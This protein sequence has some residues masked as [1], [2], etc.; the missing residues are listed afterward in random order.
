MPFSNDNAEAM[1]FRA[2]LRITR[3][4]SRVRDFHTLVTLLA[5]ETSNALDVERSTVFLYSPKTDELWSY[6]AEGETEEI[7][8]N[9]S[10][11]VAGSVF[12]TGKTLILD[13]VTHDERFNRTIDDNTGFIT[14]NMI[15]TPVVNPSGVC[16]GVFQVINKKSGA[17]TSGDAEFLEIVA[18]DTAVT[19]ENVRLLESRR[20]MFEGLI[21]ALTVSIEARDPLTAGHS[22]DVTFLSGKIAEYMGVD[23]PTA[24][25][26]YYA[27]L[28]HDY[29]KLAVPDS[30]LKK[31]GIL[32]EEE[33]TILRKHVQHTRIM[34]SSIEFEGLLE[35][36]PVFASQH[37]ERMDGKG[38]PDGLRG[39]EISIGGRIIAVADVFEALT[40]KRHYRNPY[41]LSKTL[42]LLIEGMDT[43]FD[44]NAVMALRRYLI[45]IGKVTPGEVPVE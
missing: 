20:R 19:I 8:F 9:A 24:E 4:I 33:T 12:R 10:Q 5:A 28:L 14:R 21:K 22:F 43:Q 17:F 26:I 13:D 25:A 37:H 36:V 7:R 6:V 16:I 34:L 42:N 2:L 27:A 38:Y 39:D 29:G 11:G 45:D 30:I 32:S 44:R 41:T 23:E 3:A 40:A 31:P 35:M 18:T 1:Q 15:T